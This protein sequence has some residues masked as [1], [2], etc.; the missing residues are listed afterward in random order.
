MGDAA[1][2][3]IRTPR[4]DGSPCPWEWAG[5]VVAVD[6]TRSTATT[7]EARGRRAARRDGRDGS[8]PVGLPVAGG[9][10]GVA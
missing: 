7:A 5:T 2:A 8:R 9:V 4:P 3:L 10:G 1:G 6:R